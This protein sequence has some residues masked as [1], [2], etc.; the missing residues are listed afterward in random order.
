MR[1][2][3]TSTASSIFSCT[4][5]LLQARPKIL[6]LSAL[7]NILTVCFP[8]NVITKELLVRL[9][10]LTHIAILCVGH[11]IG[12]SIAHCVHPE[13]AQSCSRDNFI[14]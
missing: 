10:G 2:H 13:I 9:K 12:N 3:D 7:S 14:E 6:F 4:F 1:P 5:G 8:M 11:V